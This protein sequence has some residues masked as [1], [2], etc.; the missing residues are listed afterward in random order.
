MAEDYGFY[1]AELRGLFSKFTNEE[2]SVF[3]SR[4]ITDGWFGLDLGEREKGG[5]WPEQ[6]G[7]GGTAI[8][9]DEDSPARA[10]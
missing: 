6:C 5:R 4:W 2:V 3:Q 9:G 10:V 8:A 1:L 7:R